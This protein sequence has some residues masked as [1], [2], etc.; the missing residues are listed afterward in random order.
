MI[1]STYLFVQYE[2]YLRDSRKVSAAESSLY[3]APVLCISVHISGMSGFILTFYSVTLEL[4]TYNYAT[5]SS[6]ESL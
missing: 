1:G 5:S 6:S 4:L 3:P 2:E